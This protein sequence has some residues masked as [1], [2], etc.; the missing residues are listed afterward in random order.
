MLFLITHI[1]KY[2]KIFR[3]ASFF[4]IKCFLN[5]DK[6]TFLCIKISFL[7]PVHGI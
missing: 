2:N 7:Q 3:F 1:G 5:K 6:L 4:V